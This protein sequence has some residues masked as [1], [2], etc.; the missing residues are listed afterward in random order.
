MN[1]TV[2]TI[3]DDDNSMNVGTSRE[4][5]IIVEASPERPLKEKAKAPLTGFFAPR[6]PVSSLPA[7]ATRKK[8]TLSPIVWPD[9]T[10][11]HVRGEQTTFASRIFEYSRREKALP[12]LQMPDGSLERP[13]ITG[14]ETPPSHCSQTGQVSCEDRASGATTSTTAAQLGPERHLASVSW[15]DKW[16]PRRAKDI[17]ANSEA[18][19]YLRDWLLA[20]EIKSAEGQNIEVPATESRDQTLTVIPRDLFKSKRPKIIRTVERP[21]KKRRVE[22]DE[23]DLD[24]WLVDDDE[25]DTVYVRDVISDESDEEHASITTSPWKPKLTRLSRSR[26]VE[27]NGQET[28]Q[29]EDAL[30]DLTP[31]HDFSDYLTNSILLSG[32]NGSGKTAAV[33][34]CAEELGWEVFEVYPG[35]GKRNGSSLMS[36]VGDVGKNHTVGKGPRPGPSVFP[37]E[38]RIDQLLS[39]PRRKSVNNRGVSSSPT[40]SRYTPDVF[41]GR[42][43]TPFDTNGKGKSPQQSIILLEEVDI[44]FGDDINFWPTVVTLIRESRRPV[45]MTC[46]GVFILYTLTFSATCL[47]PTTDA[48]LVPIEIL[49]LQSTLTFNV[50]SCDIATAYLRRLALTEGHEVEEG[51]LRALY[52][53]GKTLELSCFSHDL[54]AYS[55][56]PRPSTPDLRRAINALQFLCSGYSGSHYLSEHWLQEQRQPRP[57]FAPTAHS[58][59]QALPCPSSNSSRR[60][61]QEY[62]GCVQHASSVLR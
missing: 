22:S 33:Y 24:D 40:R 17:L 27:P 19:T 1:D 38:N 14:S 55:V 39:S 15:N 43:Q 12:Q 28:V 9:G 52:E 32:P 6:R 21:R 31:T 46:N 53:D 29:S 16:R 54:A 20:L 34:A 47:I 61:I 11:Q 49:P 42:G 5:P 60:Y 50:A 59:E 26:T 48:S 57:L 13:T 35:I 2:I 45:I 10:Q 7:V 56:C 25:D 37:H 62:R 41:S 8:P 58:P 30:K 36:L 3:K 51:V 4:K 23:E 44:L 18:A